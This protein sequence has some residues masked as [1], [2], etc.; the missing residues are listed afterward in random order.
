MSDRI[1]IIESVSP[2]TPVSAGAIS[3]RGLILGQAGKGPVTARIVR[4]IGEYEQVYGS[5]TGGSAMHDAA[6]LA[7]HSGVAELVVQRATG[8][9][10]V[11][12]SVALDTNKITVTAKDP[13]AFANAWT[14]AW[15]ASTKTLTIAGDVTETFTGADAAAVATAA[16]RSSQVNVAITALPSANVVAAS[17]SGGTDDFASVVW[18]AELARLSPDF[19]PGIVW[20]PG[21]VHTATASALAAHCA[22]TGR[23]GLV[24]A[25]AGSTKAQLKAAAATVA[26][27][28]GAERLV[29]AGPWVK[30]A[31]RVVDPCGF[32]AGLRSMAHQVGA[33]EN[34][35]AE[36]FAKRVVDVA[37][38]VE[39]NS[40]DWAELEAAGVSVIRTAYSVVRLFGWN[41]VVAMGGNANLRGA[42]RRDLVNAIRFGSERIL[43]AH[44]GK[45]ASPTRLSLI[46]GELEAFVRGFADYLSPRIG[47]DGAQIDPGFRIEV[48][49]GISPADNKVDVRCTVRFAESLDEFTFTLAVGDAGASI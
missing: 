13:G 35:R 49:T 25:A 3:G 41:T 45:P 15:D 1:T 48:S 26:A 22:L 36:E 9:A 7:F 44:D 6:R 20:I 43:N 47:E 29:L 21:A 18:A 28:D 31:G 27:I 8:P 2:A 11:L 4:S 30:F 42:Q 40:A 39:F 24:V 5:R 10:P 46:A 17:L 34:P 38:E 23:I 32:I 16:A 19:G 14:A 33:G 37:A 12:A